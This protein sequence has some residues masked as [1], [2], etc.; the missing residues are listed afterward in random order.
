MATRSSSTSLALIV[1]SSVLLLLL[2]ATAPILVVDAA[3]QD[4][5][6]TCAKTPNPIFCTMVLS[7]D[8]DIKTATTERA[9]AELAIKASARLGA[10]AGSYARRELDL[11]KDNLLWQCL[12]ECAQDI[13]DAV[14]HLD[15]AEGEVDDAKFNLVAQYLQLSEQDTWSC[16]ESCRDTP[17]CPVRTAVLAKNNDFEKMMNITNALIKVVQASAKPATALPAKP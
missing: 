2:L 4:V 11:V 3:L 16:D 9:L 7:A 5:K 13:E 1:S 8:P 17:P 12:D 6:A 10:T 15:D 14:S